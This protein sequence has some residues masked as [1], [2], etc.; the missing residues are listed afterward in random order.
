M[1]SSKIYLYLFTLIQVFFGFVISSDAQTSISGV[2]N[3]Y[4]K[5]I[6][7]SV[8]SNSI[9]VDNASFFHKNDT[10]FVIQ[11]K[12]AEI[13]LNNT[14]N[15]GEIINLNNT[16]SF[17][18]NMIDSVNIPTNTLYFKCNLIN[19][20]NEF[21]QV[22]RVPNY[23]NAQVNGTLTAKDWDGSSGGILVFIDHGQL[24]LNAD[25]DVTGKGFRGGAL[26]NTNSGFGV[27]EVASLLDSLGA[28]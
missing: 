25:I 21:T 17:E 3:H 22:V 1:I 7:F 15:F 5:C 20:Y 10:V 28:E 19:T 14:N 9:V 8:T 4:A 23:T 16:G 11:M 6:S 18:F 24:K 26:H 2:I 13:N 27:G 12:G